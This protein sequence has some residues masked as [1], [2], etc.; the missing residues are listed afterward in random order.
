MQRSSQQTHAGDVTVASVLADATGR[1]AA[2]S[3]DDAQL[4]AEVL[5]AHALDLDRA[6]LLARFGEP[7]LR[8]Q[9]AR[10]DRL[11]SRRLSR[12]PLAYI[13]G[14]R[15]FYGIPIICSPD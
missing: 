5:L 15:E 8:T 10:F 4:E 9:I 3:I 12:E 6:H 7:L 13:T 1:L 14:L 11:L 2:Q